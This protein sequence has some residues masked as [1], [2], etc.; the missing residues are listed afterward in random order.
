MQQYLCHHL[1]LAG[2]KNNIVEDSAI[3]AIH[4][5]SGGLFKKA[6]DLARGAVIVAAQKKS[7]VVHAEHVRIASSELI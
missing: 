1:A 7:S 6:N 5:E 4:Q 3:P 2:V